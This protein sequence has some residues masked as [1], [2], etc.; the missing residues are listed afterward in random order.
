MNDYA[1]LG[2]ML[3]DMRPISPVSHIGA[4]KDSGSTP[5]RHSIFS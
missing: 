3:V 2:V 1:Q 5:D 4:S